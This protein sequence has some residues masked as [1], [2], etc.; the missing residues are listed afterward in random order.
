MITGL[1]H[2]TIIVKDQNAAI[3]QFKT[4]FGTDKVRRTEP[5]PGR[6]YRAV[7]FDFG[8]N[9]NIEIIT[10]TD[11]HGPWARRLAA[12]GDGVYLYALRVDNLRKTVDELRAKG[13]RLVDDPGPGTGPI[14][15][16]VCIHPKS[17]GGAMILL[18]EK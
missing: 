13:V 16:L 10:P 2:V 12:N 7:H 4:I 17:A 6:A 1:D 18:Q 11:Q 15:N 3:E 5:N 9:N 14:T 8:S